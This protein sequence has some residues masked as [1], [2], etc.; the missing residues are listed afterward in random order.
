MSL[1]E[2]L[3]VVVA[4]ACFALAVPLAFELGRRWLHILQARDAA[5]KVKDETLERLLALEKAQEQT[6]ALLHKLGHQLGGL[7][8]R[9]GQGRSGL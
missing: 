3:G 6:G 8:Q 4:V 9:L 7:E 2:Q 1:L 5:K